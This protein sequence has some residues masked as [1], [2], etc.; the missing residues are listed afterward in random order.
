M[1]AKSLSEKVLDQMDYFHAYPDR[2]HLVEAH[3]ESLLDE[4][5]RNTANLGFH[6]G[7]ESGRLSQIQKDAELTE[8]WEAIYP[9]YGQIFKN[10][11]KAIRAQLEQEREGV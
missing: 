8:S 3:I 4:A 9:S 10:L 7:L 6:Q 1:N 11:A 2:R 5:I